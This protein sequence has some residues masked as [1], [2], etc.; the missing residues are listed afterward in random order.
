MKVRAERREGGES[1]RGMDGKEMQVREG[2]KKN[3]IERKEMK[4]EVKELR[5]KG[6]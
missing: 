6:V 4:V 1:E 3:G 5:V 2:E